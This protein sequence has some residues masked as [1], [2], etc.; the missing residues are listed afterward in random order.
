MDPVKPSTSAAD[1]ADAAPETATVSRLNL[2][3]NISSNATKD[4]SPELLDL[5]ETFA[6]NRATL[7]HLNVDPSLADRLW[8]V[9]DGVEDA[10]DEKA[11]V[12][13]QFCNDANN[14]RNND[15]GGFQR[16]GYDVP[17]CSHRHHQRLARH[18][19]QSPS[20][21][22]RLVEISIRGDSGGG[23]DDKHEHEQHEHEADKP[24]SAAR[25]RRRFHTCYRHLFPL[26]PYQSAGSMGWRRRQYLLQAIELP[27]AVSQPAP[28]YGAALLSKGHLV[29]II[30]GRVKHAELFY[31]PSP[32]AG[33]G[34]SKTGP[35]S[36]A[37]DSK[38]SKSSKSSSRS[39]KSRLQYC[40]ILQYDTVSR[41]F[42]S[43]A[44]ANSLSSLFSFTAEQQMS[45]FLRKHRFCL[46]HASAAWATPTN[47]ENADNDGDDDK[48]EIH[49]FGGMVTT[50]TGTASQCNSRAFSFNL[51]TGRWSRLEER[52]PPLRPQ[53]LQEHQRQLWGEPLM[54]RRFFD[55]LV[56]V[57]EDFKNNE[58]DEEEQEEDDVQIV[59]TRAPIHV[60]A[61]KLVGQ[62]GALAPNGDLFL[63]G[64]RTGA[65]E[66]GDG[67]SNR[68][69]RG[70]RQQQQERDARLRRWSIS[71]ETWYAAVES[72]APTHA[73]LA[74]QQ[75]Y[76][77]RFE[78]DQ[79]E[80]PYLLMVG[81][82]VQEAVGVEIQA[83]SVY[84]LRRAL[85]ITLSG[86]EAGLRQW[87]VLHGD[88]GPQEEEEVEVEE[89]AERGGL[90]FYYSDDSED[91]DVKGD[92]EDEEEEEEEDDE[93]DRKERRGGR[94]GG[95]GGREED[96]D[97]PKPTPARHPRF[98]VARYGMAYA[99]FRGGLFI[100]GGADRRGHY[101]N[102]IWR[103]DLTSKRWRLLG[104][105]PAGLLHASMTVTDQ[106]LMVIFGGLLTQ[107]GIATNLVVQCQLTAAM[108][109]E[110]QGAL[111][112]VSRER[113]PEE[114]ASAR[115]RWE[116]FYRRFGAANSTYGVATDGFLTFLADR[117][118][119]NQEK[120]E[121]F[122][123]LSKMNSA[124]YVAYLD[125]NHL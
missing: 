55:E 86:P 41:T 125:R 12:K 60:R 46:V 3:L 67:V 102:D 35:E 77:G 22:R 15:D 23:G 4:I 66:E 1:A 54:P 32:S 73:A 17:Y 47:A 85:Q 8:A 7:S 29:Y 2:S 117:S 80:P 108:P 111:E 71:M 10:A 113:E 56:T 115:R 50:L 52:P 121:E 19:V 98:P 116:H 11:V 6:T 38:S 20:F 65:E 107:C 61:P 103:L 75:D 112:I 84:H 123:R 44:E 78:A 28:R 16:K 122:L 74:Y 43:V 105:L 33:D 21:S 76:L 70:A 114:G 90:V 83:G 49:V 53:H 64:H 119:W 36:E 93:E 72:V 124:E 25:Q 24:E 82:L 48:T 39:S 81:G 95:S 79:L 94:G 30:G 118:Q 87:V 92:E 13:M 100:A 91:Y 96:E 88:N 27:L 68:S 62:A 106:G 14:R 57:A 59:G 42:S 34:T 26:E 99:T 58:N 101:L 5:L 31:R 97:A 69:I 51:L 120:V 40:N 37:S 104:R 110:L 45:G 89:E 63:V 109:A 18:L 9:A